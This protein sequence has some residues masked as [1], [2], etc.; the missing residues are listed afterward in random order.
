MNTVSNVRQGLLLCQVVFLA[1]LFASCSK[2]EIDS[3]RIVTG[4]A[5]GSYVVVGRALA[6]T[7]NE[8]RETNG[9]EVASEIS[10]GSV[11]K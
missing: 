7:V 5:Q 2:Q 10:S 3:Y 11:S 8:H 1:F 9:F 6:R 4:G